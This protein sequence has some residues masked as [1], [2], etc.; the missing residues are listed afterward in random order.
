L[1]DDI[2]ESPASDEVKRRRDLDRSAH[3]D[4]AALVLL[5][6][7]G[8]LRVVD[9]LLAEKARDLLLELTAR[10]PGHVD[11]PEEGERDRAVVRD[12]HGP[13]ELLEI[14]DR[15]LEQVVGSED[16]AVG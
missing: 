1:G 15:D 7:D 10:E 13:V 6:K 3:G 11:P 14:E 8:D 5:D 4:L 2:E 16:L 9:V 12:A